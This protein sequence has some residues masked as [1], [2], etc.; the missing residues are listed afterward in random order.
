[1]RELLYEK[2][3]NNFSSKKGYSLVVYDEINVQ[4]TLIVLGREINTL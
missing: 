1:M 2:K 4:L 3:S